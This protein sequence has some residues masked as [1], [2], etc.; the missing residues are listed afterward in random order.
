MPGANIPRMDAYLEYGSV[1]TRSLEGY[2]N[3]L[4]AVAVRD[5]PVPGALGER[6]GCHSNSVS[7]P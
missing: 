1:G 7:W 2:E 4:P 5:N 3:H 6:A